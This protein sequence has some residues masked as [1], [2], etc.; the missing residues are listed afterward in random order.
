MGFFL[1]FIWVIK[2]KQVKKTKNS[3]TNKNN[4]NNNNN[5]IA[6]EKLQVYYKKKDFKKVVKTVKPL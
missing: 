5:N 2:T 6:K 3:K 1:C 4:K